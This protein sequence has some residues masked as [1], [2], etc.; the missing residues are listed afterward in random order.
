M[1]MGGSE[2]M[3]EELGLQQL[4]VREEALREVGTR[5]LRIL[6]LI[7]GSQEERRGLKVS[8]KVLPICITNSLKN[9]AFVLY[10]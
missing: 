7:Q 10:C 3:Q 5:S 9:C 1:E 6:V 8:P 4:T 2:E